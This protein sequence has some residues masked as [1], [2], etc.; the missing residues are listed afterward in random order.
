MADLESIIMLGTPVKIVGLVCLISAFMTGYYYYRVWA[1]FF[2]T[3]NY[4]M[5]F[6][7]IFLMPLLVVSF[8]SSSTDGFIVRIII[9]LITLLIVRI[10]GLHKLIKR[11]VDQKMKG[12][13]TLHRLG[14][15]KSAF[16]FIG[17]DVGFCLF[18]VSIM[19]R[20]N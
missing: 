12:V 1:D 13:L 4:L 19:I 8:E 9:L 15:L 18:F 16:L 5:Q 17:T 2:K 7:M 3:E 20:N 14:V 10:I 11:R 6:L